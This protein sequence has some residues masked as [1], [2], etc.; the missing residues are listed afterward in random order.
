MTPRRMVEAVLLSVIGVAIAATAVLQ[1]RR[2][3][4]VDLAV[5]HE[6]TLVAQRVVVRVDT[7]LRDAKVRTAKADTVYLRARDT[8]LQHLTDTVLV[9]SALLAADSAIAQGALT[10]AAADS[11]IA[12][13]DTLVARV[14]A[15][16]AVALRPAPRLSVRASA[17]YDPL[18]QIPAASGE[19]S[20]RLIART[21]ATAV[22]S[23]RFAPGERPRCYLGLSLGF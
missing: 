6:R 22:C 21:S 15:E 17:L 23:Q 12:A 2:D 3:D 5:A 9:K 8:V 11:A 19:L 16:L 14:R 13:R 18:A 10:I 20:F 7:L 4:R 1:L